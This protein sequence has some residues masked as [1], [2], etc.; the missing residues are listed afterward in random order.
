[1]LPGPAHPIP[2]VSQIHATL[3]L[4]HWL[5]EALVKEQPVHLHWGFL[6]AIAFKLLGREDE[7]SWALLLWHPNPPRLGFQTPPLNSQKG[8]A[9]PCHPSSLSF[10]FE[11]KSPVGHKQQTSIILCS[12]LSKIL[13]NICVNYY[14]FEYNFHFMFGG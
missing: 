3:R 12:K 14:Y 4:A 6:Y 7:T 11:L 9:S 8:L 2:S 10:P 5:Q 13:K 1:M